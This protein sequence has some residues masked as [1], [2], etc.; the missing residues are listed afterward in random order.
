MRPAYERAR[1]AAEL[2]RR[3]GGEIESMV[4]GR[5]MGGTL[6]AG[7]RIR[8]GQGRDAAFAP[9]TVVAFLVGETLTGHRVVRSSRDL[10][11]REALLTRGD[12]CM[13]CDPPIDPALVVGE[14]TAW[15][16]ATGWSPVPP[17]ARRGPIGTMLAAIALACVHTLARLNL[18]LA[19]ALHESL[20]TATIRARGTLSRMLKTDG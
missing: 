14:V 4:Q 12:G 17:E 18:P 8:I 19:G 5:S 2:L 20:L 3:S 9:G 1:A 7:T 16:S 13:L 6:P 10:W 15:H 11:G